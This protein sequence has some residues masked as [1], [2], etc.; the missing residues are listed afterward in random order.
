MLGLD[1]LHVGVEIEFD[2]QIAK[3]GIGEQRDVVVAVPGDSVEFP[4]AGESAELRRGLEER[5]PLP[6]SRQAMSQ[7]HAEQ[8]A[9]EDRVSVGRYSDM[10]HLSDEPG[11]AKPTVTSCFARCR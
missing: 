9:A 5:D 4:G 8:A 1:P 10:L 11:V 6:A 2:Q 3:V 7:R